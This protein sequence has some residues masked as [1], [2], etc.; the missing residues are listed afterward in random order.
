MITEG[1]R[2]WVVSYDS[3]HE[4]FD[5]KEEALGCFGFAFSENCRLK[6]CLR[7]NYPYKWTVESL[8]NGTWTEMSTTG[9]VF[10]PFWRRKRVVYKQSCLPNGI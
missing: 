7:G 10:F 2:E 4:H 1:D 5:N 6:V 9:L 8:E 3:W